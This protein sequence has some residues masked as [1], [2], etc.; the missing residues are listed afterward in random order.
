VSS[1]ATRTVPRFEVVMVVAGGKQRFFAFDHLTKAF[2]APVDPFSRLQAEGMRDLMTT[3]AR[4]KGEPLTVTRLVSAIDGPPK[5][6]KA[7]KAQPT[8]KSTH[9]RPSDR[10]KPEARSH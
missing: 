6:V 2:R 9:S 8:E 1:E 10:H 7:E 5:P 3:H 4:E